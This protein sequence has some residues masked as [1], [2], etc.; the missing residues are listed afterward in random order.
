MSLH[1]YILV[2]AEAYS[3]CKEVMV[4]HSN[5]SSQYQLIDIYA[6]L[7]SLEAQFDVSIATEYHH[8]GPKY[9]FEPYYVVFL[10]IDNKSGDS[11]SVVAGVCALTREITIADI[12]AR[13]WAMLA[14]LMTALEHWD[15]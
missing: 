13:D 4:L 8:L 1:G 10:A 5:L 6:R 15:A 3:L 12:C 9:A 11:E 7:S 2:T 14:K